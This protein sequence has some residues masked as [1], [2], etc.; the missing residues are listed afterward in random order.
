MERIGYFWRAIPQGFSS[1]PNFQ[2]QV[3][4]TGGKIYT[5]IH[6]KIPKVLISVVILR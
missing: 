2:K 1:T 3:P 4:L 5:L 6:T